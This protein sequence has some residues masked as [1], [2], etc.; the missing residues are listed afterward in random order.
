MR[1]LEESKMGEFSLETL[2]M[3][4]SFAKKGEQAI[5]L[6]VQKMGLYLLLAIQCRP[7]GGGGERGWVAPG[8]SSEVSL[9]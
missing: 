2:G 8:S 5:S 1:D 3:M 4:A 9:F 7:G 6:E